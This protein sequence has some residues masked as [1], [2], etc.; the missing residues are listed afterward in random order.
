MTKDEADKAAAGELPDDPFEGATPMGD[1]WVPIDAVLEDTIT[2]HERRRSGEE[3]PVPFPWR[4]LTNH[5]SGGL[6]NGAYILIGATGSGK[7]QFAVQMAYNAASQGIPV[8]VTRR[9]QISH[10]RATQSVQS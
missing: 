4:C 1:G 9:W 7:T 10:V 8:R 6:W 5:F 3:S 2:L